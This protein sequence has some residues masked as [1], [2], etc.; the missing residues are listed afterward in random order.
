[1]SNINQ[2]LGQ[3]E[4]D[5]PVAAGTVVRISEGLGGGDVKHTDTFHT[6]R[7]LRDGGLSQVTSIGLSSRDLL[8]RSEKRSSFRFRKVPKNTLDLLFVSHFTNLSGSQQSLQLRR[9]SP[10][11]SH[12]V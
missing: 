2:K 11:G 5:V 1:M 3:E 12:L 6:G 10:R 8:R 7:P 4:L 9:N